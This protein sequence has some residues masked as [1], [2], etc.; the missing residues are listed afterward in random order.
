MVTQPTLHSGDFC[1]SEAVS[2][3]PLLSKQTSRHTLYPM[4]NSPSKSSGRNP[5][6]KRR[7]IRI[8]PHLL[9]P[10]SFTAPALL[11]SL[12]PSA[13]PSP[14]SAPPR[15]V[16][17]A[18]VREGVLPCWLAGWLAGC[19]R[20]GLWRCAERWAASPRPSP[21]RDRQRRREGQQTVAARR[22]LTHVHTRVRTAERTLRV[23]GPDDDGRRTHRMGKRRLLG[24]S[25]AAPQ[26]AAQNL[27]FLG[28]ASGF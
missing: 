12:P 9:P 5:S 25:P 19:G 28:D 20:P 2:A 3:I 6:A 16:Q 10:A 15:A 7:K 21:V 27:K 18:K 23:R 8:F 24:R 13:A 14:P 1:T 17:R 22:T 26:P 4:S 11:P